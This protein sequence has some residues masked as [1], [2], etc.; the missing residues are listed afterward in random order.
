MIYVR[1]CY[2]GNDTAVNLR[3]A[4]VLWHVAHYTTRMPFHDPEQCWQFEEVINV[5]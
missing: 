3:A 1:R 2:Y 4:L 5:K